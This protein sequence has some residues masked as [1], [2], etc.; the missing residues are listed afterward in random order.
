MR[1]S[2]SDV[3]HESTWQGFLSALVRNPHLRL[4]RYLR[5]HNVSQRGFEKWLYKKGYSVRE[6]KDRVA[7]LDSHMEQESSMATAPSFLPV[8]PSG[9]ENESARPSDILMGIGLTLPDGTVITIRRGSAEA[10]VS[11]LKLYSGEGLPCS[12]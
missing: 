3:R 11:F 2:S 12:D 10:V 7:Q 4:S 1:Y 9:N 5:I 8:I 6:A